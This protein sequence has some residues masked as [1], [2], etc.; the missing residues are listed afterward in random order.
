MRNLLQRVGIGPARRIYRVQ[1][2]AALLLCLSFLSAAP[3][4]GLTLEEAR[5]RCRDTVGRP[6]VRNCLGPKPGRASET[7]REACRAKAHPMVRACVHK[8]M[9]VAHGR[10]NVPLAVPTEKSAEPSSTLSELPAKFVAPPRTITDITSAL[11]GEQPD[12]QKLEERRA[13]ADAPPSAKLS[14]KELARFYYDRGNVRALLGRLKEAIADATTAVAIARGSADPGA[15]ARFQQFAGQLQSAA[16]NPKQ[17]LAF[18]SSIL[19]DANV[20]GA[21]GHMFNAYAE[22]SAF[23]LQM[24]DITQAE[25]YRRQGMA[26]LQEARTS[27]LPGWRQ[28]YPRFGQS[29]EADMDRAR[30]NILAARGRYREAEVAFRLAELRRRA[31]MP[32]VLSGNNPPPKTQLLRGIDFMVLAQAGMKAKQGRLAEA[33]ADARRALLSRLADQGRYDPSTPRFIRGLANILVEQGRY[34]EAEQLNRMAIE[35]TRRLGFATDSEFTVEL[36]ADL[37]EILNYRS[38]PQEAIAVYAELEQAIATWDPP[39]RRRF[40]LNASR[41]NSLY[42]SGQIEAGVAAAEALLKHNIALV[43][44]RHFGTA[45]ARGT[46]AIGYARAGRNADAIREFRTA[47]PVLISG[48][49]ENTDLDETSVVAAKSGRL[50]NIAETY[51]RLLTR[52]HAM[53]DEQLALE[54]FQLADAIRGQSVQQALSASSARIGANDPKLAELVRTEQDLA[55]QINAGLGVLNNVLSLPSS[56]RDEDGIRAISATIQRAREQ[57]DTTRGEIARRFPE[58]ADLIEPKPPTLAQ[59]KEAL[60]SGEALL[61]FYFGRASS[62]VWAVPKEGPVLLASISLTAGELES[63]VH[64]LREALAPEAVSSPD[65]VPT[66]DLALAHDLYRL[67]LAPIESGWRPANSLIVV[68]NGALGLLPLSLLPITPAKLKDDVGVRFDA[69]RDVMWLA[70]THAVMSIPSAGSLRTLRQLPPGSRQREPLIGFGDPYFTEEQA[71]E[72]E[73]Q[74][75]GSPMAIAALPDLRVP[76]LRRAKVATQG[77]DTADLGRLPRLPDTADELR[78][79]ADSLEV[80]STGALHLGRAA[81]ERVVK[82]TDL[83]RFRVIAFATHGLLP[84]DLDGLS[85]PALALSAPNVA[86]VDGDGLLTMEEVLT[87]KLNSDWVV[88]SACNTGSGATAGAEAVSG[89]GRAFFYAGT[90]TLLVTNWPVVSEAARHLVTD[91]FKRQAADP[92]LARAEALRHAMLGLMD[93]PGHMNGGKT[94]YSYAH[95]M[96]WAPYT[97]VGDGGG[98]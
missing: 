53:P 19:R 1:S 25:A 77:F 26:L 34:E 28:N 63:K 37:A 50:K 33:E 54:T 66:F 58:Y 21:R 51:M 2:R 96:F 29:W 9:N 23:S 98:L 16:G 80:D 35:I 70:R 20:K 3:A 30:A 94:I 97:I 69:Y 84:G 68:T 64:Q 78:A 86:D 5:E 85:Q 6:M 90:R 67:L 83:T 92:K 62:F 75:S 14:G 43:G 31:A 39:R 91:I 55:K 71:A 40:D 56:E 15:V 44:E 89:L 95:P 27:G 82:N 13:A 47:L 42:A 72:A 12:P 59:I 22:V 7:E 4:V 81:N 38:M 60:Q 18:F 46:L 48:A 41:I 11:E 93:G 8:A 52:A 45:A 49:R 79:I 65:D 24:G 87:L 73:A 74:T 88:L 10:P 17:A 32:S 57:R 36:L 61:S 76:L